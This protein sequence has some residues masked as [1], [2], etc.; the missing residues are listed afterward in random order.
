V[1]ERKPFAVLRGFSGRFGPFWPDPDE[2]GETHYALILLAKLAL[3]VLAGAH[4]PRLQI[5]SGTLIS[6]WRIRSYGRTT[7]TSP[8][9]RPSSA[10]MTFGISGSVWLSRVPSASRTMT[11]IR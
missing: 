7:I 6:T 2:L 10:S 8:G 4:A 1:T 5:P 11:A 9:R 3:S